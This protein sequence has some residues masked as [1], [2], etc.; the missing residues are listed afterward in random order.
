MIKI[1]KG[2]APETEEDKLN[3]LATQ[4]LREK[5]AEVFELIANNPNKTVING[6]RLYKCEM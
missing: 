6:R 1:G 3:Q 4:L 2:W 5:L